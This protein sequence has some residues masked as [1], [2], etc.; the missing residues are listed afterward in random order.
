MNAYGE[1]NIDASNNYW[2]SINAQHI[3]T[4]IYD[5]FD[6]ANL[7]VASF[8]PFLTSAAIVDTS[9]N[10]IPSGF[11]FPQA[12]GPEG[13]IFPNPAMS[14]CKIQLTKM[15]VDG[16]LEVFDILGNKVLYE[17]MRFQSTFDINLQKFIAGLYIVKITDGQRS[18][19][20]KLVV[21]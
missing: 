10:S 2:G 11:D 21:R 18:L 15:I 7:S 20:L 12:A 6:N 1:D 17:H 13:V 14:Y 16:S 5:F 4:V 8:T 19:N 9:C 3:D